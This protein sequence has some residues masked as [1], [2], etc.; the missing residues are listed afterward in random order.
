M[1]RNT[2][3][4]ANRSKRVRGTPLN[5]KNR[6][7]NRLGQ[8]DRRHPPLHKGV[9]AAAI[10]FTPIFSTILQTR[11]ALG[12]DTPS[13]L[14]SPVNTAEFVFDLQLPTS[15]I[16]GAVLAYRTRWAESPA[17]IRKSL[18][19]V[20]SLGGHVSYIEG[21]SRELSEAI[22]PARLRRGANAISF[23]RNSFGQDP[24]IEHPRLL[25]RTTNRADEIA[26]FVVRKVIRLASSFIPT[27]SKSAPYTGERFKT[28]FN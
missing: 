18:N 10:T 23:L 24:E 15:E 22:E 17:L 9:G 4:H 13:V 28:S 27:A 21:P 2:L 19:G 7:S 3:R 14:P 11:A 1:S 12:P 16:T 26:P 20:A 6:T 5:G 25:V 8:I